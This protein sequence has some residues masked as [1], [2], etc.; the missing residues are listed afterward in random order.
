MKS[1]ILIP[2]KYGVWRIL[3]EQ[4]IGYVALDQSQKKDVNENSHH[5]L[6]IDLNIP[7]PGGTIGL[8]YDSLGAVEKAA[9]QLDWHFK[10]KN[11]GEQK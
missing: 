7:G 5:I 6:R 3:E 9:A 8:E 11:N 2:F 10:N 1:F 4:I